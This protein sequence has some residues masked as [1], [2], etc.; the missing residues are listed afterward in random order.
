MDMLDSRLFIRIVHA[1]Q[2]NLKTV[3]SY[4]STVM[5]ASN[6]IIINSVNIIYNLTQIIEKA[7][8]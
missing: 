4:D 8:Y 5:I 7:V 3:H 2:I 6:K 1:V